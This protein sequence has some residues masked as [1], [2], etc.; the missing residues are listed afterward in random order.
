MKLYPLFASLKTQRKV[1]LIAALL[2]LLPQGVFAQ[3]NTNIPTP[4]NGTRCGPGQLQLSATAPGTN[5][6]NWYRQATGGVPLGSGNT[7]TTPF[8]PATTNF[9]ATAVSGTSTANVQIGTGT[10]T[11]PS[12]TAGGPFTNWYRNEGTQMMYTASE[13]VANG[14]NSGSINSIAFNCVN[15]PLQQGTTTA[16]AF[17]NYKIS[18]TTVPASV[19]TLTN[20][21]PASSFSVVYSN[22][23]FMP[24]LGWNVFTFSTPLTWNGT[25]NI[26]IQICYDQTQPSYSSGP[27]GEDMGKH[28]YTNTQDRMLYFSDDNVSTSCGETGFNTSEYLPNAKFNLTMPC[29]G[30]RVPVT[31]TITSGPT[32]TKSAP[33]IVCNN[34][35]GTV[36]VISPVANYSNYEWSPAT[37]LYTDA[38]TTVP[39]TGGNA[40]TLYFKSA[41]TG[42][43]SF[44]VYATNTAAPNCAFADTTHIWVQ[45][46]AASILA[47]YD[48]I[49]I[50]GTSDLM[51][52]PSSGYAAGSVQW[53][54]S[55]AGALYGNI[56]GANGTSLTTPTLTAEH[57]YKA[58]ISA[59]GGVCLAPVKHIAVVNPQLVS[60]TDSFNCGP[61]TVVLKAVGDGVSTV[62]WYTSPIT[63]QVAGAGASFTTPYLGITTQ[64][65]VSAGAGNPQ[66]DP[67]KIG[68]GTNTSD[69]SSMPYFS[70]YAYGNKVQWKI[71]ATEM[72]AAG[73]NAGYITSVGFTVGSYSGDACDNFT[74][75]MKNITPGSIGSTLHTGLQ[76]VFSTPSYQPVTGGLNNHIL[77]VPFHWDGTSDIV[78]E[79]CHINVNQS[80]NFT[81][82]ESS[83][84]ECMSNTA[85]T[86]DANHCSDPDPNNTYTN[87]DRPNITIGMKAPCETPRQLVTAYIRP[88]PVVA[89]GADMNVCV[90]AGGTQVLDAGIQPND[91]QYIWDDYTTSQIRQVNQD[92][93]YSVKVTNEYGCNNSDTINVRFRL[94]PVVNLGNDTSICN[95]ATLTLD[96]GNEGIEYF[97]NNGL[98]TETI[99]IVS[100]GMYYVFVTNGKGCIKSD[101][102]VVNMQGQLPTIQDIQ[103]TNNGQYTFTFLAYNPQNVIG[104]EWDFGDGSPHSYQPSPEHTYLQDGDYI[105]I[106]KLSSSCGSFTEESTAHIVGIKELNISNDELMVFPNPS[107][108]VATILNKGTLKMEKIQIYNIL[109]Q[110]VYSSKADAKDKHNLILNNF[111]SGVYTIEI[112][113]DKG[114]V[115]RKLEI[116]K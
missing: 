53:Q 14:G 10:D 38:G 56:N 109:G 116:L 13:I 63:T 32:F 47:I 44:S 106:L 60:T 55:Y 39:Y 58:L 26:I 112:Y 73:F 7:F 31:A 8:V 29:E 65:Y 9:Y 51:L 37:D 77:Q 67:T 104:Y 22:A 83:N 115:P 79:E 15:V 78:L 18:V 100:E 107:R 62:R 87:T 96:A 52:I 70:G 50:S 105:V 61:G 1:G 111:A 101:S 75:S 92:G 74:L 34:A 72:Q 88:K 5:T 89:L 45:P 64:Y 69:W 114:T 90:D 36:S 48:T 20:W 102:I 17:P 11:L 28:E 98:T 81:E 82:V 113:T 19:S 99:T 110:M 27:A 2:Y 6:V 86:Y 49:C 3:C 12:N 40:T 103:V 42:Q 97:W 41:S 57:D 68:S 21:E 59:T 43:H 93:T 33:A 54:E 91:G 4:V 84:G 80:F 108:D 24:V 16:T 76:T 35:A 46:D 94:N 85:N 25:D 71:S 95:G 23:S 30:P 66:P